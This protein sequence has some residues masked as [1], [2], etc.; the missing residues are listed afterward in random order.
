MDR[1]GAAWAASFF[2]LGCIQL[3]L[4]AYRCDDVYMA[5]LKTTL[6]HSVFSTRI[7]GGLLW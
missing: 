1:E 3:D 6:L 5:R 4:R 2:A 7:T